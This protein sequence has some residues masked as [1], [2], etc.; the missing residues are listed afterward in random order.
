MSNTEDAVHQV[1]DAYRQAVFDRDAEAFLRLYELGARVFDA[2]EVW[3][4]EGAESRRASVTGW[5]DSLGDERVRVTVED[6][7][8]LGEPPWVVATAVFRYAAFSSAGV[9]LRSMQNRLTWVLRAQGD[10]WKI[11]HEHTSMPVGSDTKAIF[12]RGQTVSAL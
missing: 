3:S 10:G 6:V 11:V 2:W 8:V 5:F 9:E 7:Q 4:Y 1:I 12:K